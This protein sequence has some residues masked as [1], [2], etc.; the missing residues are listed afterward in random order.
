MGGTL[1]AIVTAELDP[2]RDDGEA[3]ARRLIEAGVPVISLRQLDM[4]H[5]GVLWCR[6]AEE[7]SPGIDT[8]VRA[9]TE[10]LGSTA[11]ARPHWSG[12]GI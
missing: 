1:A 4:A 9:L 3:Y 12:D 8:V 2:L 11:A 5:C 7:V 10:A 6:A